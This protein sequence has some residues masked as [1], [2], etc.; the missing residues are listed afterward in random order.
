L[1]AGRHIVYELKN[2]FSLV[3]LVKGGNVVGY[4]ATGRNGQKLRLITTMDPLGASIRK[5][6]EEMRKWETPEER[7]KRKQEEFDLAIEEMIAK[8]ESEGGGMQEKGCW[9]IGY[10]EGLIVIGYGP[11]GKGV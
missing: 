8:L 6:I 10:I 9:I 7:R 4:T 11:C 5:H 1:R 3:A 2:R